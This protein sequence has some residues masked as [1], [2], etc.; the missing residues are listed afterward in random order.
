MAAA[1]TSP[2]ECVIDL[3]SGLLQVA[4]HLI[5]PAFGLKT[6]AA[7]DLAQRTEVAA[8]RK[9]LDLC[10]A[11]S[12]PTYS[13]QSATADPC[14]RVFQ[15][16][17]SRH[18]GSQDLSVPVRRGSTAFRRSPASLLLTSSAS[19]P[20]PFARASIKPRPQRAEFRLRRRDRPLSDERGGQ[21]VDALVFLPSV[22][23]FFVRPR[24]GTANLPGQ[25]PQRPPASCCLCWL[26]PMS[27]LRGLSKC[28][29]KR[30]RGVRDRYGRVRVIYIIG[31]LL[32]LIRHATHTSPPIQALA[33]APRW[34]RDIT[35]CPALLVTLIDGT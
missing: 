5:G 15:A 3:L 26:R 2:T 31:R 8:R 12:R 4:H 21:G 17:L 11:E 7:G 22:V 27:L 18:L 10:L 13:T 14:R 30:I 23:A 1:S 6:P 24:L 32:S 20:A 35:V 19:T 16:R 25:I 9:Q 29:S 34:Y 33:G 28:G